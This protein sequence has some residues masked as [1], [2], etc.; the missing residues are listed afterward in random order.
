MGSNSVLVA[1][2][3]T[4]QIGIGIDVEEGMTPV[5]NKLAEKI[6]RW[7]FVDIGELHVLPDGW[8]GKSEDGTGSSMA[9][10]RRKHQVTEGE[11]LGPVL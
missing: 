6:W 2:T 7:E 11:H 9:L 4:E 3:C 8:A 1:P 5:L 10:M